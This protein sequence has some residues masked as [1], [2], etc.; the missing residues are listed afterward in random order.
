MKLRIGL[1][2]LGDSWEA[3]HLPALLA[4]RDRFEIH[5][6]FDEVSY[7]ARQVA[8]QVGAT[9]VGGFRAL[10]RRA[11]IDAIMILSPQWFGSQPILAACDSGKSIYCAAA[12]DTVLA[13]A[14]RIKRHV[15]S[16]GVA[17]MAEFPRRHAPATL[18]LKELIATRIGKPQL[19]FC[20]HRLLV[21]PDRPQPEWRKESRPAQRALL[22]LVDWCRYVVGSDPQSVVGVRHKAIARGPES[23]DYQMMSLDFSKDAD[24]PGSGPMAQISCGHYMP[25]DW[26]EALSFRPP[27]A[28]QVCCERG[29][30]FI[31]LP[32]TLI[33]FDDAGRHL[34]SL[35]SEQPVDQQMLSQFHRE[36]TS[37]FRNSAG[38]ED[39]YRAVS[40]I[41]AARQSAKEGCRISLDFD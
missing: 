29:V 33:W 6:V 34:E 21:R 41:L 37:L 4:L 15:E 10:I 36:V 5:G 14:R 20:H 17:F 12:L 16:S 3:R 31:D 22:E 25:S 9:Q 1:V 7:R 40:I 27:A 32:S 30:A 28:L 18:R 19:L 35:E 26:H 11:D 13:E 38:L 24:S 2:G 23:H 8:E 39:A